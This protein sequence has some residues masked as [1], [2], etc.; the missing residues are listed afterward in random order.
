MIYDVQLAYQAEQDLRGIYEYFALNRQEPRLAKRITRQI[1]DKLNMLE[2]MPFRHPVYQD[3]PWKSR[4][5]RQ[6]FAGKYCG[7][8][9]VKEEI[10]TVIRIMYG[11]MDLST[12]LSEAEIDDFD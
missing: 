3:E 2:E 11:G 10:V 4:G 12:A 8:Y 9:Y 6:I 7:F 1:I 5:L